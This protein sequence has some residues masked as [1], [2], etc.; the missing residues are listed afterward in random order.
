MGSTM[1]AV[2]FHGK[3]DV[4]IE[5]IPV[6]PVGEHDVKVMCPDYG[7]LLHCDC[8]LTRQQLRLAYC[9]ICGSGEQ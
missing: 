2:R 7:V 8:S 5:D 6:P 9:G 4:R 1:K 3:D